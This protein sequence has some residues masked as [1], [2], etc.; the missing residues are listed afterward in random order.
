[1]RA[2]RRGLCNWLWF[3]INLTPVAERESRGMDHFAFLPE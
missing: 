3:G 1:M 2:A